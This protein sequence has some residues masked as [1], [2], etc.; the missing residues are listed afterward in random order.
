MTRELDRVDPHVV[1]TLI[2]VMHAPLLAIQSADVVPPGMQRHTRCTL[3]LR[4]G[5][6]AIGEA[7]CYDPSG[8]N[9]AHDIRLAR[10]LARARALLLI[11]LGR[12]R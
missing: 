12:P 4:N 2:H 10:D 3:W 9:P 5:R 7:A 1:E 11:E 8:G 6:E